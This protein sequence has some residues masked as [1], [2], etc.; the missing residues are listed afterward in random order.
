IRHVKAALQRFAVD[1]ALTRF[2]NVISGKFTADFIEKL[3]A[4]TKEHGVYDNLLARQS[5]SEISLHN[6]RDLLKEF[7]RP[8]DHPASLNRGPATF[9]IQT[10][11][12]IS[13]R[14]H[15]STPS[16]RAGQNIA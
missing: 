9:L 3:H 8:S 10:D 6:A 5:A 15:R 1:E 4:T 2:Q 16:Q 11:E 14:R 12:A 13:V 7:Q